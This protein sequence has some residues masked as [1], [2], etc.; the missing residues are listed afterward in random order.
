MYV[1][2]PEISAA[3]SN[4]DFVIGEVYD[5]VHCIERVAQAAG[6][7]DPHV[8]EGIGELAAALDDFDVSILS[9]D[10]FLARTQPV[11]EFSCLWF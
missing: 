6:P 9:C 3:K 11:S 10:G 1:R 8:Y 7:S 2:H 4:R 5:A